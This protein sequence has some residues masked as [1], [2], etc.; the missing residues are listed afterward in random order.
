MLGWGKYIFCI[1]Y[2]HEYLGARALR[3]VGRKMGHLNFYVLILE[4]VNMLNTLSG[5]S[6]S[7]NLISSRI[8]RWEDYPE[9]SGYAQ[10]NHRGPYKREE[11]GSQRV[12][13]ND[14][15]IG[16]NDT[17]R[18]QGILADSRS[19]RR[20]NKQKKEYPQETPE[21]SQPC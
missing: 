20:K 3:M 15:K 9:L 11:K 21:G 14:R 16:W 5:K 19:W 4:S 6:D 18:R 17:V 8:L 10:R 2:S 1:W 7:A 12:R 13:Y